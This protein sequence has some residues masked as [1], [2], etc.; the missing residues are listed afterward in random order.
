MTSNLGAERIQAHARRQESFEELKDDM[1]QLLR[2]H[3]RPE[4]LNRIDEV[5]VFRALDRDQLLAITRLLLDKV[6]RR[7]HAQHITVQF[8][9]AAVAWL[10][11]RGF[12][13][14]FGARPLRRTIQRSVENEL[15]RMLLDGR[16][17]EGDEVTVDVEGDHLRFDVKRK[18]EVDGEKA[19]RE[20]VAA[21]KK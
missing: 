7:L 1:M 2:G 17:S 15:S 14:E 6:A 18:L 4:F 12:D 13:P 10:A 8:A 11:E 9:D 3:F 16:L 19:K 21:S 5:I 20:K